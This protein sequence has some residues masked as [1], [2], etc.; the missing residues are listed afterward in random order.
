MMIEVRLLHHAA[1]FMMPIIYLA[2]FSIG[3]GNNGPPALT[4]TELIEQV[5]RDW[6]ARQDHIRTLKCTLEGTII[7]PRGSLDDELERPPE[8]TMPPEDTV[9]GF[10]REWSVDFDRGLI[11]TCTNRSVF[12]TSKYE[13]TPLLE[14]RLFDGTTVTIIPENVKRTDDASGSESN[15][16]LRT[17]RISIGFL[18]HLSDLPVFFAVGHP[19]MGGSFT[20]PQPPSVE[21]NLFSIYRKDLDGN[22][23]RLVVL[24]TAGTRGIADTKVIRYTVDL[25]RQ[26]AIVSTTRYRDGLC[27]FRFD[28]AQQL[29]PAGWWIPKSW[30]MN[31]FR[32]GSLL[33]A[34]EVTLKEATLNPEFGPEVFVHRLK[35]GTIVTKDGKRYRV[36]SD[37]ESMELVATGTATNEMSESRHLPR[38]TPMARTDFDKGIILIVAALLFAAGASIVL[39]KR[40]RRSVVWITPR[41]QDTND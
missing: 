31:V 33:K 7:T 39:T 34:E 21:P 32:N 4:D 6:K 12:D 9:V 1:C 17:D 10:R 24:A 8:S 30:T 29:S 36:A 41:I 27:Q 5:L 14:T 11:R 37:C 15:I 19:F 13:W 20:G 3:Y 16:E 40:L 28:I 2:I 22:S 18:C 25:N 38:S 23:G 35:A 26:S